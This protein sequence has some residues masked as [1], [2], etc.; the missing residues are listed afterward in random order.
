MKSKL[1]K[2]TRQYVED[3]STHAVSNVSYI[4]KESSLCIEEMADSFSIMPDFLLTRE[5]LER[6]AVT[7]NLDGLAVITSKGMASSSDV[8]CELFYEWVDTHPEMCEKL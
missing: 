1:V 6:K 5:V 2:E 3:V 4:L 8:F 7:W